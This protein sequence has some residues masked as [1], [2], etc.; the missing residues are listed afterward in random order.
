MEWLDPDFG[1]SQALYVMIT[2]SSQKTRREWDMALRTSI[3][4]VYHKVATSTVDL[5][6]GM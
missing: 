6:P 4:P 1:L 3:S 2:G 5:L